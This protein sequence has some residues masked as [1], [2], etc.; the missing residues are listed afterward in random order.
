[1]RLMVLGGSSNQVDLIKKAKQQGDT[2]I[3]VDYLSDCAGKEY[4]DIHLLISTFDIEGIEKAALEYDVRGIVT[5]GT[6]Q[7]ILSAASASEK[8]GFNFYCDKK[9]AKAVTNKRVMKKIFK[10]ND[11]PSAEYRL[12]GRD[13]IDEELE[14][15]KFPVVIKPVDAQGQRG[16][17]K[18][19]SIAEIREKIED[20]LS[21]SSEDKALV[22]EYFLNDEITVNGWVEDGKTTI[23]SVVDRVTFEK[24][25]HIGI[26]LCH[27]FPSVH[28]TAHRIEIEE[29]TERIVEAFDI[30]NGPIYFQY[31]IGKKRMIVNE[32]AMRI[33]GAYEGL[34]LP[35]IADV[36][37]LKMVLEFAKYGKVDTT[38]LEKYDHFKNKIYLST[39]LFFCRPGKV[40]SMTPKEELKNLPY[41]KTVYY[42]Y[43][44]GDE[45]HK[46]ENA[47]ARAGYFIAEGNSFENMV[48]NVNSVFEKMEILDYNGTNLVVKYKEY[49]GKY[50]IAK[51]CSPI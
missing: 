38:A 43:S 35:M 4:A 12:I 13:F 50:K 32:I 22:E 33:G 24:N 3:L 28:L 36:D 29:M 14:S 1:M 48:D 2:V 41:L 20:T 15:I 9:T 39:Q 44:E 40:S 42:E 5:A 23:L 18:L 34:T 19:N 21:Y 6:D 30:K 11:I 17:Y 16:V 46:I 45:I 25:K 26:C 10:A 37:I 49:M 27:N 51:V 8:L 47:T 7:P 31:L